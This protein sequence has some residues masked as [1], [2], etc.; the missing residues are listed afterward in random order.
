VDVSVLLVTVAC[1]TGHQ[2][3]ALSLTFT[4]CRLAAGVQYRN[5]GSKDCIQSTVDGGVGADNVCIRPGVSVCRP[6]GKQ[7]VAAFSASR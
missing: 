7:P 2:A 1:L 6:A 4:G 5:R 3:N